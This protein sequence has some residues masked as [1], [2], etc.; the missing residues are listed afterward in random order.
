MLTVRVFCQ[1][2]MTN[3]LATEVRESKKLTLDLSSS[4]P[5]EINTSGMFIKKGLHKIPSQECQECSR[6][7]KGL[8]AKFRCLGC[9]LL[10]T[11]DYAKKI[12]NTISLS[13]E[14]EKGVKD[15]LVPHWQRW[16][17]IFLRRVFSTKTDDPCKPQ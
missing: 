8:G 17:E 13:C 9:M 2:T 10:T 16:P 3:A 12:E 11:H 4:E 6:F 1:V 14:T 7:A 5:R 15:I